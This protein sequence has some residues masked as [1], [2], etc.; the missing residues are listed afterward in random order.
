MIHIS[1]F[2]SITSGKTGPLITRAL[3]LDPSSPVCVG[4]DS[5]G[6]EM[7]EASII[8]KALV[9]HPGRVT[10]M[11]QRASSAAAMLVMAADEIYIAP[12]GEILLHEPCIA[13][14]TVGVRLTA[15]NLRRIANGLDR[16][17]WDF[18]RIHAKRMGRKPSEVREIMRESKLYVGKQAVRAGLADKVSKLLLP[19]Q[20]NP[21]QSV[22]VE[23]TK[24]PLS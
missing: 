1:I 7:D 5:S 4:L 10:A 19:P 11:V 13:D 2:G 8:Y 12:E 9:N 6:G 15:T 16:K 23:W 22:H 14:L 18:A 3:M 24:S 20:D 17:M 21:I